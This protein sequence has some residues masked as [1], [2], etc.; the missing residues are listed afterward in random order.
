M[1]KCSLKVFRYG[2]LSKQVIIR[3]LLRIVDQS[4]YFYCGMELKHKTR[5]WHFLFAIVCL[6][7]IEN[8][9][10]SKNITLTAKHR[11]YRLPQKMNKKIFI[12]II[13]VAK[14][15]FK[16]IKWIL[17][18]KSKKMSYTISYTRSTLMVCC[19]C[20][21]PCQNRWQEPVTHTAHLKPC[22]S[23]SFKTMKA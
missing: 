16:M 14:I 5:M 4:F 22:P 3:P 12:C 7:R 8:F 17:F 11:R 10:S 23:L 2:K 6:F 1:S 20:L 9:K 19:F 15:T 13:L 18:K 21:G